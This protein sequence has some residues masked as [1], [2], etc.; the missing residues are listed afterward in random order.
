GQL[1]RG[2]DAAQAL[3]GVDD[4]LGGAEPVGVHD[5]V[6]VD[7]EV[8]QLVGVNL[9]HGVVHGGDLVA[10]IGLAGRGVRNHEAGDVGAE[11][12]THELSHGNIPVSWRPWGASTARALPASAAAV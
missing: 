4:V 3:V 10:H 1:V 12:C 9:L 2:V 6:G 7:L 8:A 11:G 5:H